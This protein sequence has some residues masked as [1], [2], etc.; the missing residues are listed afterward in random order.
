MSATTRPRR[1][2]GA[3][4]CLAVVAA[5]LT[6]GAAS[7]AAQDATKMPLTG[8]SPGCAAASPLEPG[9][10]TD[11]TLESG[12]ITRT[13]RVH[14]PPDYTADRA[15]PVVLVFHG[16][17]NS[18]PTTEEFS[19]LSRLPAIVAYPDGVPGGEGK[20]AWQ[21]ASYSAPGVDD[22]AFTADL[23]DDLESTL[24]V[25][26]DRV[27]ATGKSNGGGF[28][29]IL[30]C[31]MS[32]RIASIAPVAGAYYRAGEPPC[33]PDRAVPVLAIHGTGDATIPYTGDADRGLP[34]IP[35]WVEG[36]VRRDGCGPE[37][38]STRIE[39]DVTVSTWS[40]CTEGAEVA[41]VAVDGGGHTWPGADA[42]SG[43]GHTTQ[44]IEATDLIGRFAAR[45]TLGSS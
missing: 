34:A 33:E 31:R 17:G 30:A 23:L 37:P 32:D 40:G 35:A 18:G 19:G 25:D 28:T 27:H 16:R 6:A 1:L 29:E 42:Y 45:H 21:G 41:H 10:S 5:G 14:V 12:G 8:R 44:T 43:G 7:A 39:P 36:W 26:T 2:L 20:R 15:W 9:T 4:A 38:A 3:V 24:C 11:R 22:V 13:V